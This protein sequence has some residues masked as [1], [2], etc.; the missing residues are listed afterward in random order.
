MALTCSS[1]DG[2]LDLWWRHPLEHTGLDL[3]LA[4]Q[5]AVLDRPLLKLEL[6]RVRI[7]LQQRRDPVDLVRRGRALGE[8]GGQLDE[9][10]EHE[11]GRERVGV[12]R[13][14]HRVEQVDDVGLRHLEDDESRGRPSA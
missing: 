7:R 9:R 5:R 4:K 10:G 6:L 2:R 12:G 8:S 13:V 3:G 11:L 14:E 1:H